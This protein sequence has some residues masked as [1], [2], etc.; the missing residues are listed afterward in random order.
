MFKNLF[1]NIQEKYNNIKEENNNLEQLLQTTTTFQNLFPIQKK[2]QEIYEYKI[3]YILED[4]PDLNEDKAKLITNIIPINETLLTILYTIEIISNKEYYLITTNKYLW[5][6]SQTNYAAYDY[7]NLT[8]KIIKNNLMSKSILLNNILLE[9]N[10]NS[11][12]INTFLNII[13][14]PNERNIIIKEKTSYLQGIMPIYQKINKIGSGISLDS[15]NNIVFHTKEKN[16][17]LKKEEL[18]NYEILLDNQI[19]LSKTST[20][21]KSITNFQTSC[22]QISIRITYPNNT[23]IIPILEQNTFGNKYNYHDSIFQNNLNFA[24]KIIEKL[25]ELTNNNY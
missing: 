3:S 4:C 13:N 9:A 7:N 16:L 18:L 6:I 10:G 22:Y 20:T 11:Q 24:K 2:E 12:K 19:Y 14:Q 21:S 5:I 8:C 23:F 25:N 15:Q 17:K 1:N